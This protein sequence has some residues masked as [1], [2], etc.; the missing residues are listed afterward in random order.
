[1]KN[2]DYGKDYKYAHSFEN[3]FA[4]Q[5]F[6]PDALSGTTFYEPGN[7]AREAEQRNYLRKLWKEKYGY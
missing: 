6:L 1:M 5:E 4:E 3:N 2:L 7:N